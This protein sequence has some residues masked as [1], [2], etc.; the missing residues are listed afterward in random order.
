MSNKGIH[1]KKILVGLGVFAFAGAFWACSENGKSAGTSE[2]AEGVVALTGKKIAGVSQKGPLVE[3]SDVILRETSSE[4]NL[5]PTGREFSTKITNDSGDFAFDGLNLESPYVLLSAEGHYIHDL[6][7]ERS[8][9]V[10]RLNAVSDLENRNTVN[11]NLLTHF[12]YKRVLKL[13]EQGKTFAEAKRQAATEILNEF[14]VEFH[15]DAPEDL[16]IYNS[17]DADRTLY[18]ISIFVDN[19]DFYYPNDEGIDEWDFQQDTA[20]IDCSALQSYVDRFADDLAE[21]GIF[22]DTMMANI[23][24]G[25]Y[26]YKGQREIHGDHELGLTKYGLEDLMQERIYFR[27]LVLDHYL[28]FEECNDERWG[29]SRR[30]DKAF[31]I[32]YNDED[33]MEYVNPA[34][35]LCDGIDWIMTTKGH[36]DSLETEIPH[37]MG[38]MT[39]TRDGRTY[40]TLSFED[41]GT[42][43]EWMAED[44]KYNGDSLYSWTQAMMIDSI[45]MKSAVPEGLI[46]SV[47]QGI[48]PDGWHVSSTL[49]WEA[50]LFYVQGSVNLLDENWKPDS[51]TART[52][53][54]PMVFHNR[55]DFNILPRDQIRFSAVYHTYAHESFAEKGTAERDSIFNYFFGEKG[56]TTGD[57]WVSSYIG[58]FRNNRTVGNTIFRI[59]PEYATADRDLQDVAGVRC[60]KN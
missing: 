14:G 49:D 50:L 12:E 6:S 47:H 7:G 22:N 44:L 33:K 42:T 3:G 58:S 38:T 48:C 16:N 1:M 53:K 39:D 29:E 30:L 27:K 10:L 5:E 17:S 59:A 23:V 35:F 46:D 9:C 43:Y 24:Y 13:V 54:L 60:V 11:I 21:D 57:D 56:Y 55:F 26:L 25:A 31:G 28:G 8:H 45:Y 19:Q 37:Q 2:E 40:K 51:T 34:Y 36:I 15:G 4:G 20:N 18:H 52:R 32:G 41:R